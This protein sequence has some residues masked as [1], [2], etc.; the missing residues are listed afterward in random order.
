MRA[1]HYE[2]GRRAEP[3]LIMKC[4]LMMKDKNADEI[5]ELMKNPVFRMVARQYE[6]D[7]QNRAK[8]GR[9]FNDLSLNNVKKG[10]L[11]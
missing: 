6:R 9:A 1:S 10:E 5:A 8:H 7:R 11:C 4:A 2:M 3:E